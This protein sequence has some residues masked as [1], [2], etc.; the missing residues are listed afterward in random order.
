M[1]LYKQLFEYIKNEL[2]T[3]LSS[4]EIQ[5]RNLKRSFDEKVSCLDFENKINNKVEDMD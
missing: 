4:C 3:G 2:K 1:I 5:L